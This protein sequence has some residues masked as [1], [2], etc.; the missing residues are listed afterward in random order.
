MSTGGS[1]TNPQAAIEPT[2][3][4]GDIIELLYRGFDILYVLHFWV[5]MSEDIHSHME[6]SDVVNLWMLCCNQFDGFIFLFFGLSI[7]R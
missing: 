4:V 2:V 1:D 3:G 6:G 7:L 5:S